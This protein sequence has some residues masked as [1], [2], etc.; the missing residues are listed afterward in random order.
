MSRWTRTD[1]AQVISKRLV[2][3]V[4]SHS[5]A[6]EIA[7]FLL[8]E[9]RTREIDALMRTIQAVRERQDGIV[10]ATTTSAFELTEAIKDEVKKLLRAKKTILNTTI[11]KKVVGGLCIETQD[12]YLD[13]TV[14]KQL[15]QLQQAVTTDTGA[16]L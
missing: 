15:T 12:R 13:L 16:A 5:L 4:D 14:R 1:F 8:A 11:D 10:E 3:G 9:R 2:E 7:E 6:R